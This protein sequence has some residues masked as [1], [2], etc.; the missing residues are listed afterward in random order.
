[1]K[2][3]K[4]Y[5]SSKFLFKLLKYSYY[6]TYTRSRDSKFWRVPES[7]LHKNVLYRANLSSLSEIYVRSNFAV[8]YLMFWLQ[9]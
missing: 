9:P 1:M 3:A 4:K 8:P 5:F 7:Y 6:W 2:V